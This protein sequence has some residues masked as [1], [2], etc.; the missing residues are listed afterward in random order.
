MALHSGEDETNL[1]NTSES[2]GE[3]LYR[4]ATP[5]DHSEGG[6]YISNEDDD[7]VRDVL[8]T[9]HGQTKSSTKTR[10]QKGCLKT[11]GRKAQTSKKTD[12][13]HKRTT[14][15]LVDRENVEYNMSQI[16][17]PGSLVRDKNVDETRT[18][19]HQ[20]VN[21]DDNS[22]RMVADDPNSLRTPEGARENFSDRSPRD[23]RLSRAPRSEPPDEIGVDRIANKHRQSNLA[24]RDGRSGGGQ[25]NSSQYI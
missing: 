19:Y 14:L 2:D 24:P 7:D 10:F 5:S 9:K 17:S 11:R 15:N 4:L 3:T 12:R 20:G 23:E 1:T 16:V 13:S 25:Q 21:L 22:D 6:D 8:R 18:H